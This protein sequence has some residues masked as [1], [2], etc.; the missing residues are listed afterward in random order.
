[1][2]TLKPQVESFRAVSTKEKTILTDHLGLMMGEAA[3][4]IPTRCFGSQWGRSGKGLTEE[5]E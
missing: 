2:G 5:E 4:G 3:V 1:M